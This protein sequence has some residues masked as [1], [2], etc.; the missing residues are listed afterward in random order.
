MSHPLLTVVPD[1]SANNEVTN[2]DCKFL[3]INIALI[4]TITISTVGMF[5]VLSANKYKAQERYVK[6]MKFKEVQERYNRKW[7]MIGH[8]Q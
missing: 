5:K 1:G 3:H 8:Q 6:L 2:I 7:N 4:S